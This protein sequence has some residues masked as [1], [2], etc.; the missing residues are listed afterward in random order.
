ML[1]RRESCGTKLA[2]ESGVEQRPVFK[3]DASNPQQAVRDAAKRTGVA[4]T[5]SSEGRVLGLADGVMLDSHAGP[6]DRLRAAVG[7]GPPG[8]APR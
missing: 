8:G 2:L 1:D 5:A 6:N 4:V 7:C 3:H